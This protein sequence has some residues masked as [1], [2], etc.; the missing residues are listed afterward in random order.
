MGE[1]I[2]DLPS[3]SQIFHEASESWRV[4]GYKHNINL[5]GR[6]FSSKRRD[7][8]NLL[9]IGAATRYIDYCSWQEYF[10]KVNIFCAT[11]G[12]ENFKLQKRDLDEDRISYFE[13]RDMDR[14]IDGKTFGAIIDSSAQDFEI[15][16]DRFRKLFP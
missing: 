14:A 7:D 11:R 12:L 5:Y 13:I 3:L 8:F 10:D 15:V 1:K 4:R 16:K 6:Y 2:D 9:E